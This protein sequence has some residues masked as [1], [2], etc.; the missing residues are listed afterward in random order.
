M[1]SLQQ[2][3][4]SS[5]LAFST[6]QPFQP[7]SEPPV[8]RLDFA[9]EEHTTSRPLKCITIYRNAKMSSWLPDIAGSHRLHLGLTAVISGCIAASAVI[10]LQEAKRRYNVYDLKESIPDP[11]SPHD[12]NKVCLMLSGKLPGA[13]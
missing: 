8:N 3:Q 10:G 7:R 6:P 12:V 11:E 2:G 4:L 9:C 1:L 13:D 5:S